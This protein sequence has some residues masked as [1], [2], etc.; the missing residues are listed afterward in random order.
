MFKKEGTKTQKRSRFSTILF[1]IQWFIIG[2]VSAIDCYWSIK[3]QESLLVNEQNPIGVY[4]IKLDNGDI[5][6][7]MMWKII[8]T[9]VTLGLLIVLYK[10]NSKIAQLSCFGVCIFQILL[11]IYLCY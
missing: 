1:S 7:F 9:I 11:L 5:A 4:L 8:G 2:L 6:L 3:L 10:Y